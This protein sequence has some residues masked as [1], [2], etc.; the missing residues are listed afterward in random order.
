MALLR[1][2][3]EAFPGQV[4]AATVDHHLRPESS[5]EAAKVAAWAEACGVIH[6]T[7]VWSDAEAGAGLQ[8]RARA[9]R[10]GLLADLARYLGSSLRSLP[11]V[12]AHTSDDQAETVVMRLA[13]SSGLGGLAGMGPVSEL[14]GAPPV[15]LLRPL[16]GYTR[17][18]LRHYLSDIGQGWIE[19]PSN[20]D[21]Q[22]ER[23]RVRAAMPELTNIGLAPVSLARM[24]HALG[25]IRTDIT[26][27]AVE[28][29]C[30]ATEETGPG[31][32]VLKP[33]RLARSPEPIRRRAL[34]LLMMGYGAGDYP[35]SPE[36]LA[37]LDTALSDD[38]FKGATLA[39]CR[40]ASTTKGIL[41]GREPGRLK[42]LSCAVRPG[43]VFLWDRRF[44]VAI[45]KWCRE[46]DRI[47]PLGFG[48]A[49]QTVAHP[50]RSWVPEAWPALWRGREVLAVPGF[51]GDVSSGCSRALSGDQLS[52]IG[53]PRF[54]FV[55]LDRVSGRL[56]QA[57]AELQ[58]VS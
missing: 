53:Q 39:G 11:V 30:E 43:Q 33:E 12:T 58:D 44:F 57:F 25:R 7:L 51:S 35:P 2:A 49:A 56:A 17:A 52:D 48:G 38:A 23:V 31:W 36:A 27:W 34:E 5:A 47:A 29:I 22:F 1:A 20:E 4:I 10:Y 28:L 8:A 3:A 24:A 50:P 45:P 41:V 40:L 46:T 13:R 15:V 42:G 9:A 6:H 19:D 55:G 32:V 37:R 54:R 18:E 14:E 21:P 16:L 26:T